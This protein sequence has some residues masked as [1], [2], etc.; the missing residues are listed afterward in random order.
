MILTVK[1]DC[2]LLN[3]IKWL[4]FFKEMR[5]LAGK[6]ETGKLFMVH[7]VLAPHGSYTDNC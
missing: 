3:I 2:L 4:F 6:K 1:R 5:F 7:P